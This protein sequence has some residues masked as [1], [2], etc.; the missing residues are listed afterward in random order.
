MTT[1]GKRDLSKLDFRKIKKRI[2]YLCTYDFPFLNPEDTFQEV[3]K[4]FVEGK[5]Q[6][7]TLQQIVIDIA[8]TISGRKGSPKYDRRKNL[9]VN[10]LEYRVGG[11][12]D[13]PYD[14]EFAFESQENFEYMLSGIKIERYREITRKFFTEKITLKE[15]GEEY[16]LTESR[17]QQIITKSKYEIKSFLER[18]ERLYSFRLNNYKSEQAN[19]K[20]RYETTE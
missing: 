7:S 9:F 18:E 11:A 12:A 16:N 17:I 19:K 14:Q 10:P 3:I 5:S 20:Y 4:R 1:E 8:R 6:H 15:L 13:K 2:V